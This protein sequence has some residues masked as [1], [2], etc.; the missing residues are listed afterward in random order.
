M[1]S[2]QGTGPDRRLPF[3]IPTLLGVLSLSV[4]GRVVE[5]EV[6]LK[7]SVPCPEFAS[8]GRS[9]SST[10]NCLNVFCVVFFDSTWGVRMNTGCLLPGP[11]PGNQWLWCSEP[12]ICFTA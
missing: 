10:L 3:R 8:K 6:G 1:P 2:D 9:F 5:E 7:A 4:D 12:T 11:L